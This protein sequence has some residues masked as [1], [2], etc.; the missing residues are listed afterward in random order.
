METAPV[1]PGSPLTVTGR[2]R[3]LGH[4][5]HFTV[6]CSALVSRSTACFRFSLRAQNLTVRAQKPSAAN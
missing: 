1:L 5:W 4:A 2:I 3:H 6:R